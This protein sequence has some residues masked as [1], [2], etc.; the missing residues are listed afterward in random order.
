MVLIRPAQ[1]SRRQELPLILSFHSE[2]GGGGGSMVQAGAPAWT[3]WSLKC[4]I[5]KENCKNQV[6][7]IRLLLVCEARERH[8]SSSPPLL[9]K[10][11]INRTFTNTARVNVSSSRRARVCVGVCVYESVPP[12]GT[13]LPVTP[14]PH[15]G[16]WM[17][18][19][20]AFVI[21]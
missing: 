12:Y 16:L 17:A 15:G 5:R 13:A 1:D 19:Y 18:N 6:T 7:H 3:Q 14:S 11:V 10:R 8:W 21:N 9:F 20:I 2:R 4:H